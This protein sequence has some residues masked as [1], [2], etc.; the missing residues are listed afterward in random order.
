MV[1]PLGGTI[2]RGVL[3]T[4]FLRR[5]T[6]GTHRVVWRHTHLI[7]RVV[8]NFGALRNFRIA[9]DTNLGARLPP[10]MRTVRFESDGTRY[11]VA[12]DRLQENTS[13]QDLPA[14]PGTNVS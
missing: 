3:L 2:P 11:L 10:M 12:F 13:L 14:K 9:F 7:G 5:M 1:A 6:D 8:M 4:F